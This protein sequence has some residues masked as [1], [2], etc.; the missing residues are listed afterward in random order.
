MKGKIK[1]A[2]SHN[3]GF[4]LNEIL[5]I[6]AAVIIAALIIIPGLTGFADG[7]ITKMGTWWTNMGD[8]VFMET[9]P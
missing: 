4:G 2:L 9:L 3:D 8:K 5:G 7:L 6:A 1:K